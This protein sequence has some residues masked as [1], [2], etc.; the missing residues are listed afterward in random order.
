MKED[1]YQ[2]RCKAANNIMHF[3]QKLEQPIVGQSSI[4]EKQ[5]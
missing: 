2:N 1:K 3:G 4:E 5:L